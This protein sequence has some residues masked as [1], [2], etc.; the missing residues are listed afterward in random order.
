MLGDDSEAL[1]NSFD[2]EVDWFLAKNFFPSAR[3]ILDEVSVHIG[4]GGDEYRMN[5]GVVHDLL[6]RTHLG[7]IHVSKFVCGFGKCV[8]NCCE[9]STG[10][11]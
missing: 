1:A 7:A 5:R 10:G 2:A 6:D 11:F 9:P 4:W 8:G 3:S